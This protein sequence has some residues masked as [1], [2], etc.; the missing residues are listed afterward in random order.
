MSLLTTAI[1]LTSASPDALPDFLAANYDPF[2]V[3]V[4]DLTST[5]A[6]YDAGQVFAKLYGQNNEWYAVASF[7]GVTTQMGVLLNSV[8]QTHNEVKSAILVEGNFKQ[9]KLTPN[10]ID[11]GVYGNIIIEED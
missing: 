9:S 2:E 8:S 4:A 1:G 10:D 7:A 6:D 11:A 3:I 5:T